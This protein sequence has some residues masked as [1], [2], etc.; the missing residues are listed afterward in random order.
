MS[1]ERARNIIGMNDLRNPLFLH[2]SEGPGSLFIQDKLQGA[3]NYRSW[4]RNVEIGLAT[5][6]K[7][8]FVQGTITRSD[9]DPLKADMWDTYNSMVIAWLQNSVSESIGKSILFLNSAREIWLQLEHRFS[10]SNGSRKYR[11]NKEIYEVKQNH[12]PISEYYTRLRCYWEELEAMNEL[13]K[14]TAI[15]D[16]I[17]L[18]LKV[19]TQQKE[20]QRLFQFLNGL[21]DIYSNQRSQLLLMTPLPS[22]EAACSYLQQE[23][24]QREVLEVNKLEVET[25]AFFS[26]SDKS[27]EAKLCSECGNKGHTA[28]KCWTIIGYPSWHPKGRKQANKRGDRSQNFKGKGRF[29]ATADTNVSS[30]TA[31]TPLQ[32]EQIQQLMKLLPASQTQTPVGRSASEDDLDH[33]FAGTIMCTQVGVEK[34]GWILDSGATDHMTYDAGILLDTQALQEKH[35]ITLPNGELS[36]ITHMGRVIIDN[37]LVLKNVLLVP[38]F[39]YN[40]LSV[41]KLARDNHCCVI[42]FPALC[43]IQDLV[44]Q[45][46]LGIGKAHKGLYFLMN[47][48]VEEIDSKLEDIIKDMISAGHYG[49]VV[50]GNEVQHVNSYELWHK[51]LGHAP[52]SKLQHLP[53][54]QLQ[55]NAS[56]V[57]IVCP[58]AKL[59]KLPYQLSHSQSSAVCELLHMDIWGPYRVPTHRG[60]RYFLTLVDDCTRTTWVYLLKYKSQAL[61]TL[62]LFMSFVATQFQ[63]KI[64]CIR[65]DNALEFHS[66]PCQIFFSKHG[67]LQQTSCV[68]RPQQ[69][70][71]V[72]RKHRHILEV[73]RALRFQAHLPIHLWGDCVLTAVYI[74]NRL[75]S[76]LLRNKTPYERL[77]GKPPS[78]SHMRTFGCLAFASNPS[79]SHDKFDARGIPCVFLGYPPSQK[80]YKLLNIQTQ[81]IFVSRDVRF[82]EHVFPYHR[83]SFE[84]YMTPTLVPMCTPSWD[85]VPLHDNPHPHAVSPILQPANPSS[86]TSAPITDVP[87]RRSSR[88]P[89]KPAWLTDYVSGAAQSP[90][91]NV[92]Y[93]LTHHITYDHLDHNFQA[94]ISVLDK[95]HDPVSF[96]QAVKSQVWCNAMN[97]ELQALERNETWELTSLPPGK[98]PI[99]CKWLFKTKYRSDGTIDR[100]KARLVIQGFSQQKGIDYEETFAPVAKMATVRTILAVTAMKQWF[101]CHMDVTNAFLHGDLDEEVYMKL[102]KGYRGKGEPVLLNTPTQWP[103]TG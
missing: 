35:Q 1:A 94:F 43:I 73:A 47:K 85:D 66:D 6:R 86:A 82:V 48:A 21:D 87:V 40:L 7:L 10:I 76:F 103:Q 81:Q 42:F 53:G 58:M 56:K 71:R 91:K 88:N 9:D 11:I 36:E 14:L 100:H 101:T 4:R 5:K 52:F 67:I 60:Y 15:T 50:T 72:E 39:K 12:T 78:Y 16:E 95:Q 46:I 33:N 29:A 97:I 49:L 26:K 24:S 70:G 30:A 84:A 77:F 41:P 63:A 32:V 37:K 62:Q 27:R 75:P 19:F 57:C 20:E 28:D 51:R 102:P 93:P 96:E 8:G 44:T 74:I 54:L 25:T 65:S 61:S 83:D 34:Q 59:T 89:R 23:E 13:P 98:K 18:F 68:D 64:K 92:L 99:G 45:K 31:L 79:R 80:G 2:P 3:N 69:N 90:T 55:H 22:V 38:T 17:K